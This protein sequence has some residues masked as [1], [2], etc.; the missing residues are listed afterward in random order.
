MMELKSGNFRVAKFGNSLAKSPLPT[1]QPLSEI[2]YALAK[3]FELVSPVDII[4]Y[5]G[6]PLA[7]LGVSPIL[8]NFVVAFVVKWGL[9]RQVAAAGL[10]NDVKARTRLMN[11]VVELELPIYRVSLIEKSQ[12]A[13][14]TDISRL[15]KPKIIH[16]GSWIP[17]TLGTLL[18]PFHQSQGTYLE[19]YCVGSIRQDFQRSTEL[20]LPEASIPFKDLLKYFLLFGYDLHREGFSLLR[21][22]HQEV[23]QDTI[24]MNLGSSSQENSTYLCTVRSSLDNLNSLTLKFENIMAWLPKHKTDDRIDNSEDKF[25]L[26]PNLADTN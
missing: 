26:G 10:K 24:L 5:I 6:V 17:L 20:A 22:Q 16:G 1:H 21:H 2:I 18:P 19:R 7:V 23:P 15:R 14:T 13:V 3:L 9:K 12:R 25:L 4:T 8:Y 11:S